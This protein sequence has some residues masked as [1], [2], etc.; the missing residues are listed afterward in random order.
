MNDARA[1]CQACGNPL[2]AE[3]R[4]TELSRFELSRETQY[5]DESMLLAILGDMGLDLSKRPQTADTL[6]ENTVAVQAGSARSVQTKSI[7][8]TN[9]VQP[10]QPTGR[11][12]AAN[13][14]V[15]WLVVASVALLLLVSFGLFAAAVLVQA[16]WFRPGLGSLLTISFP[17]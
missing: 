17:A 1:F 10:R 11:T 15:K 13:S 7:G 2:V 8:Q 5:L 6:V 16:F 14:N 4:R 9:V 3:A 12:R